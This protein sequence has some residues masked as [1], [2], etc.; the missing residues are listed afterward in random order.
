MANGA[1]GLG[2]GLDQQFRLPSQVWPR[3]LKENERVILIGRVSEAE[4]ANV[5]EDG[6]AGKHAESENGLPRPSSLPPFAPRGGTALAPA[7]PSRA[8]LRLQPAGQ[9]GVPRYAIR[10]ARPGAQ[11][12]QLRTSG[13][14][15]AG[16]HKPRNSTSDCI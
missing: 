2:G 15:G 16:Q 12:S 7:T 1:L 9:A 4:K 13:W 3:S 11:D 10:A 14:G 6:C 8:Q 5:G